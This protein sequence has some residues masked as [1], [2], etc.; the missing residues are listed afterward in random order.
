MQYNKDTSIGYA[1][2]VT[3][4]TLRKNF[5][6]EIK[7]YGISSEQYGVMKIV[8]DEPSTP[9]KIAEI[10]H[11]DKATITRIIKSLENKNLIKKEK[12]NNRSFLIKLSK[13]GKEIL[14]QAEAIAVK[15]YST[16]ID[17]VGEEDIKHLLNT[18]KQIRELFKGNKWKKYF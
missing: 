16:I 13:E 14:N 9:T 4:N 11:R 17:K 10:L 2:T 7:K 1:L 8:S 15:Y 3:L 12:I 18:L 5:N 6:K